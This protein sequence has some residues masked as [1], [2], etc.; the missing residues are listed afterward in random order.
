[1]NINSP[2]D[3]ALS[4][5]SHCPVCNSINLRTD[6]N[7]SPRPREL[8]TRD[9]RHVIAETGMEVG[10]TDCGSTW[11]DVMILYGYVDLDVPKTHDHVEELLDKPAP[12]WLQPRADSFLADP[13]NRALIIMAGALA[14]MFTLAATGLL[15]R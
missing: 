6:W 15:T 12:S 5:G 8:P 7:V 11:T 4:G 9:G 14:V 2:T 3:H 10:C 1:M 13:T